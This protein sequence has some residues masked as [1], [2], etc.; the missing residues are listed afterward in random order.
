MSQDRLGPLI[1]ALVG[2]DRQ[3]L[4]VVTDI[5]NRL[6]STHAF[7]WHD[8]L[9][10][11]VQEGLPP[12]EPPPPLLVFDEHVAS[13]VLMT[14]HVPTEFWRDTDEAPARRVGGTFATTVVARAKP[15]EP[16][17]VVK[18]P[19][20]NLSRATTVRDILAYPGVGDFDPTDL[21]A[22]IAEMIG[23]QPNGE[24]GD[25]LNDGRANLFPCV[26]VLIDVYWHV[27]FRVWLVGDWCPD[28]GVGA[29]RSR[30]FSGNLKL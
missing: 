23:Q 9:K 29:A 17:S 10:G 15:R 11:V 14:R 16:S 6:N 25:L 8:R 27:I 22:L 26:S 3:H 21:S 30:V 1:R 20:A 18:V 12:I 19:Y 13:V 7:R 2:V 24:T 5:A 4:G 28:D